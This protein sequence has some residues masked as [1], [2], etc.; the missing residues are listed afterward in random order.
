MQ[1]QDVFKRIVDGIRET[2]P[3]AG[4]IEFTPESVLGDLPEWDSMAAVNL[5]TYLQEQFEIEV[6]LELL[7]DGTKLEE[8]AGF[9]QNPVGL[10]T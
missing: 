4:Q 9:L 1:M 3:D 2:F 8:I 5:Q 6:P 7:S 10:N